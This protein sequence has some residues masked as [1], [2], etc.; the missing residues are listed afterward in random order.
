[1]RRFGENGKRAPVEHCP[2]CGRSIEG[3]KICSC[4]AASPNLSFAERSEFELEQ[5][6][7]YK[8]RVQASA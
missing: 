1:M 4:G 5:W 3:V 6:R 8:A 2:S 7:A